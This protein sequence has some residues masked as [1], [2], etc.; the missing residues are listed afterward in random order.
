MTRALLVIDVQ[1]D[2]FPGGTL[3]LWDV[4]NTERRILSAIGQAR[5]AGDKIIL[6]QH[7]STATEGLFAAGG[8]GVAIRPAIVAA[9][10]NAVI[11]AKKYAD[12][13][14]ETDLFKHLAAGQK[15]LVCGMMTQNCVVF[16]AMSRAADDFEVHVLSDLCA[17]PSEAVHRIALSALKSKLHVSTAAE[18]L[19]ETHPKP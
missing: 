10:G 5:T 16:T 6:V 9:S 1:N 19:G 2:Y 14:Q 12:A 11:V 4:E 15:L 18:V 17:A 8:S 3:P 13:F 7:V